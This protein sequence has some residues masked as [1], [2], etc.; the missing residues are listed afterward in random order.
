[1]GMML[2]CA[3]CQEACCLNLLFPKLVKK[4]VGSML[5]AQDH[6]LHVLCLY[7]ELYG[8]YRT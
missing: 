6:D 5:Y 7:G 1:M 8:E 4:I 3:G 2:L